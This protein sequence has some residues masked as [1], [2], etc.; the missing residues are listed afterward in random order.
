MIDLFPFQK[1]GVHFL[2]SLKYALLADDM[3]LGKT[4]Q[5][6]VACR[7]LQKVLVICPSVAK[8]NWQAEF[9][10]FDNRRFDVFEGIESLKYKGRSNVIDLFSSQAIVSITSI[11]RHPKAFSLPRGALWDVIIV[12]EAHYLKTPDAFRTKIVLGR[13]GGIIHKT[14]RLWALSGTPTPNH[15]GELWIWLY[16]FGYTKLSYEGFIA[17]YCNSYQVGGSGS[18]GRYSRVQIAGSNTKHTPELKKL[19]HKFMLRRLKRE[20]LDL[21]PI[22]HNVYHVEE[23]ERDVFERMP[24]LKVK[25]DIERRILAEKLNFNL[26]SF[27]T[28]KLLSTLSLLS[29]S[30][31]A[32]RRY[33]GLKKVTPTGYLISN[34]LQEGQYKKIIIF[35]IHTDVLCALRRFF[36]NEGFKVILVTGKTSSENRFKAQ[37]RFQ[38]SSILRSKRGSMGMEEYPIFIGNIQAAGVNLTLTAATQVVFIEQDWV[39]GNNKQAADRAHRIGQKETVNVRHICI[40]DSIDEKITATLTRKIQ[41]ISTFIKH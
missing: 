13:E 41:E 6:I 38:K 39:P 33:H 35:G 37:K 8:F 16:T 2:R 23:D 18:G 4:P 21:P 7:P 30:V 1:E 25:L 27:G 12:D 24:E 17:R 5:A 20:V 36:L 19:L 34:E 14:R 31:S 15:A 40:K 28:T 29:Q 22:F 9:M 3:G 10:R 32:L 26:D 11:A